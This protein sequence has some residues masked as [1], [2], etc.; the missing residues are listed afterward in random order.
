MLCCL[1]NCVPAT[2]DDII[3]HPINKSNT[4]LADDPPEQIYQINTSGNVQLTY[5]LNLGANKKNIYFVLTYTGFKAAAGYPVISTFNHMP[6]P[7]LLEAPARAASPP[8]SR[9]TTRPHPQLVFGIPAIDRFNQQLPAARLVQKHRASFTGLMNRA[10]PAS[11]FDLAGDRTVF[12]AYSP[13]TIENS[14]DITAT[15]RKIVTDPAANRTLNIW[16]ADDCQELISSA[17]LDTL[18]TSRA[19]P[20]GCCATRRLPRVKV[21]SLSCGAGLCFE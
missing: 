11:R 6:A 20:S 8:A 1:L 9:Q 19:D 18:N 10:M 7:V 13:T 5:T 2:E 17:M 12:K 21:A 15:C 14:I 3:Y 16:V 4:Y